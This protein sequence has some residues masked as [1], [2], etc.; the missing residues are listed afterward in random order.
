M[1]KS[2]RPKKGK[3]GKYHKQAY[4]GKTPGGASVY[5]RFIDSDWHNL[6]LQIAQCKADF[7]SGKLQEKEHL[8]PAQTLTFSGAMENYINT[9]RVLHQQNPDEYSVSTIAGYASVCRS[10]RKNAAFAQIIDK[11]IANLT[12]IELQAALNAAA[13]P[14]KAGKKL[15]TK[16]LRNWWGLIKPTVDT[17]GPPDIRLDKIK[18]AKNKSEKP[19]II[20]NKTIPLVLRV[21]REIGDDFF[22]YILFT[23]VLGT[24]PSEAYAFTWADVSALPLTA[25]ANGKAYQYGTINIDKARVRDEFGKYQEKTPKTEAGARQLSRHWSFFDQLYSVKPRGADSER[26]ISMNPNR[27]PYRWKK[28]KKRVALPEGMV[29]YDLRHYHATVMVS[30]GATDA[31]IASDMGHADIAVTRKHYIEELAETRQEI[32]AKMFA[33]TESL[34]LQ[35][36]DNTTGGT[37]EHEKNIDV[38]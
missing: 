36:S 22:L 11:P 7:K 3:D 23:A 14:N 27:L 15:A 29:L 18:V 5:R 2:N 19:L 1:A 6:L 24:R 4:I 13:L 30:C 16:T 26:I 28:L 33:H 9:C 12:V 10:I 32:N 25:V 20:S 17:Y 38:V 35:F 31:Y 8:T 34:I 21:A 37:T